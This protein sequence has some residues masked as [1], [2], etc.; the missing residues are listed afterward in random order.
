MAKMQQIKNNCEISTRG[1]FGD[2]KVDKMIIAG[3]VPFKTKTEEFILGF[4][5]KRTL[6][7]DKKPSIS[8]SNLDG[9]GMC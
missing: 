4:T 6:H 2:Y 8:K 9:K 5:A 7:R 1:T 3:N